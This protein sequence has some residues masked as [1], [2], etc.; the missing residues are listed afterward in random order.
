MRNK[1]TTLIYKWFQE[2][3]NNGR[4]EAIDE[5]LAD[6][7]IVYGLGPDRYI[8]GAEAFKK[9]Y[10]EFRKQVN[11]VLVEVADV[12]SQDD[13]ETGLCHVTAVHTASK[14]KVDF[15]GL[16]MVRIQDGKIVESWNHYDFLR[17]YQQAGY[18]L[19]MI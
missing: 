7:V 15:S 17:M 8:Q 4:R 19:T 13:M 9:F 10:D 2:V 6:N 14:K 18:A 11:D 3:W 5:F 16:C 1:N 12:V